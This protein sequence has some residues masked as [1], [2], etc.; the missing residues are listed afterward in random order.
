MENR[1]AKPAL[2]RLILGMT[3]IAALGFTLGLM[4]ASSGFAAGNQGSKPGAAPATNQNERRIR[5]IYPKKGSVDLDAMGIQGELK[6]PGDFYFQRRE[7][8]KFDSLVKRRKNF[9]REMLR[10][11]VLSK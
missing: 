8:E 2:L 9:H 10:D 6:S 1:L 4:F 3:V 5:I 11:A 7:E